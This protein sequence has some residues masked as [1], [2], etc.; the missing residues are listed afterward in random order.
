[1]SVYAKICALE[2]HDH[3]ALQCVTKACLFVRMHN[4]KV[5]VDEPPL[6]ILRT[7]LKLLTSNK[8]VYIVVSLPIT[9]HY[10]L[11]LFFVAISA[12]GLM[13]GEVAHA[14]VAGTEV[15]GLVS[16]SHQGRLVEDGNPVLLLL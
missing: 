16:P 3:R 10:H 7:G 1:M 5:I 15:L 9:S 12:Q 6:K 2:I 14:A 13:A 4:G 8:A 11:H